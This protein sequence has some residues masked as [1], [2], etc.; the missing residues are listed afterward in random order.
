MHYPRANS[1]SLSQ[2]DRLCRPE[3]SWHTHSV[4]LLPAF[5]HFLEKFI[6][7]CPTCSFKSPCGTLGSR[8]LVDCQSQ[9]DQADTLEITAVHQFVFD[10]NLPDLRVTPPI[11]NSRVALSILCTTRLLCTTTWGFPKG[12]PMSWPWPKDRRR[13]LKPPSLCIVQACHKSLRHAWI[14]ACNMSRGTMRCG[15][16]ALKLSNCKI[17]ACGWG[18][19]WNSQK[20]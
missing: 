3:P 8:S 5:L 13:K 9:A 16:I 20:L 15:T 18:I 4:P 10:P 2:P 1:V 19:W 17:P 11:S 12:V 14:G 7:T 6:F